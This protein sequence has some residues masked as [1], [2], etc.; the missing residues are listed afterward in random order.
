MIRHI[1]LFKM[2]EEQAGQA[3]KLAQSLAALKEK[4]DGYML[5][6]ETR[7]DIIH[8]KNSYDIVLNSVFRDVE[9]LEKY[10]VHPEH[11]KVLVLIQSVC[12]STVKIDYD[13]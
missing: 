12:A 11:V 8:A 10:R 1:V 7:M 9:T 4:T 6:C 3:Q 2:K 13:F 5:E